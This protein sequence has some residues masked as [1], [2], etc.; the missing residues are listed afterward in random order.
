MTRWRRLLAPPAGR[1]RRPLAPPAGRRRRFL[2]SGWGR[3]DGARA[4]AAQLRGHRQRAASKDQQCRGRVP[5]LYP[6]TRAREGRA[7]LSAVG[8]QRD[9]LA[10]PAGRRRRF[11]FSGW[12]R[13]DGARAPAAQLRGHRQRAAS[14]D[15]QCRGRVPPLYPLTR[16]REGRADLSAVGQQRDPL[17][18]P[19]GRRRRFLFS[20]WGR[21]DGARA[22]AAQ[23][24]GHRQ[25]AASKDQQCRGRVPPLYPL[26]R[27]REGRADLSAVGQQRDPL[28]P[29][30]GRRRRFLFSGWGRND[31]ARAP[32][33]QLRGH[34]QRA[35]SKDQQ[36]R[37]R[38]PPLYPLTRAREGRADLSA[39][40]Q[41]RDP[42]APPAGRRRRFLF[43][44]WGRNDGARA[45]AAQLRG[46]RQRAASKDQQCR[47]RVPPLYPLTRAREGRADLSAVGQQRDPLAPPA[48]RR[49]RF[50]FSGWGRNDGAR[51]PA[52]QLRGHRQR[53]ASKDQQCRGRVPPLYPLTRA[54]EGRADLSAVGQQR[55]PLAPPAGRRRRF[56]F[57]GWG[58][59]DG[60][61]APAAQLR[62]HRQRAA[63]KDQQCRG[64]VP[65]LYPLTRAREG[66]ADLS[67]VGQQRDP[68]APPAGRRRRFLFS[69]WGRNDGA[70]APAAQLRGHRQR[71]ASKDQQ[72]R[73]RVPPLYPLTR[74]REGRADLSAV[75]QQRDPLAPP[76][77]RRRRFLFS[78]W[79]R[80]DGARA[81]AAQLRGHRQ[82][83]A[84]KDQQC[85]GRV[86]PLYLQIRLQ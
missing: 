63:S 27:A 62:G 44:G 33:A 1:R 82:R 73:G 19:A 86:P 5:P 59:N 43:S 24:R 42:L 61:R 21:N 54:R 49:R 12:G 55:D 3:N 11:L 26:T 52:A 45:P 83:A 50:L 8:Q 75:G 79:G 80:N 37:G 56:L 6:L 70:R 39:V 4:P 46:H 84:S 10:P 65:P 60:A 74:A 68:L 34:R 77:G 29:P 81:P 28:A 7:D 57:S 31:G 13:N 35:A 76:A 69:G 16:A 67:A 23:L 38:V 64:R 47:G 20:G 48:G 36:C 71:A 72:C 2:F 32:A 9:P 22:P 41:Q 78:G 25:R 53:A 15:Q 51:A 17:A 85:R 30:A 14:K 18:P 58:R 40:G 66:R